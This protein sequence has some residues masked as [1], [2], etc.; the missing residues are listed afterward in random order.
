MNVNSHNQSINMLPMCCTVKFYKQM[1]L[2][3][4]EVCHLSWF[5]PEC[6]NSINL[7]QRND[8]TYIII[9]TV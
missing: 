2:V 5:T 3:S 4:Q 8:W 9:C 6:S 1:Q 7:L